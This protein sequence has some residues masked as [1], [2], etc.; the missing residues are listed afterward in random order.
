MYCGAQP[1]AKMPRVQ[2]KA[3]RL[4]MAY[5]SCELE[6]FAKGPWGTVEKYPAGDY[7]L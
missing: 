6:T 3:E 7:A 4:D 1:K 2:S 5:G